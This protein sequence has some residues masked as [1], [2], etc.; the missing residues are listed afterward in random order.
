MQ[1]FGYRANRCGHPKFST[2]E[3]NGRPVISPFFV[4]HSDR[5]TTAGSSPGL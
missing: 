3:R 2:D 5:I 4:Q 1:T